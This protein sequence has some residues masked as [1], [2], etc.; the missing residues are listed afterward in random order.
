MLVGL[1]PNT[2]PPNQIQIGC[3]ILHLPQPVNIICIDK[4]CQLP[5]HISLTIRG[6][7]QSQSTAKSLQ[8]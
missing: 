4:R 8:D 6:L 7:S 2:C 3:N 5:W 1:S